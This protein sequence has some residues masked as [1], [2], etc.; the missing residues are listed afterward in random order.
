MAHK[1]LMHK[2]PEV[3]LRL[4]Y[5]KHMDIAVVAALVILIGMFYAFQKSNVVYTLTEQEEKVMEVIDA[6]PQT[7]AEMQ[8]A[9]SGPSIPVEAESEDEID[10]ETIDNTELTFEEMVSNEPPPPPPDAEDD[11]IVPFAAV[12]DRPVLKKRIAPIY[13]ELAK[14]AGL[15]GMVTV[16]VLI[17]TDGRVEQVKV[18]KSIPMLDESAISA[19]KQYVF[20]PAKQRDRVV[21]V[22]MA[23]P[24]VFK[25]KN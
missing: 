6:P 18:L 19:A 15:E 11:I 24:I 22:W 8:A 14:K 10:D 2:N 12:S 21:K 25:L 3:D 20:T 7:Q 1:S 5:R 17:G 4:K 13:P 9:P 16:S 23:I